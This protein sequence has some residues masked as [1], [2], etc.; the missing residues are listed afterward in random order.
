MSIGSAIVTNVTEYAGAPAAT[1]LAAD[2]FAVLCHDRSFADAA[3]RAAWE[4][5]NPGLGAAVAAT[6]EDLV[7][8]AVARFGGLDVL[9]SNDSWPARRARIEDA[10]P[11]EYRAMLEALTVQ[12]FRL[13]GAAA[14][15]M[16]Q[17]GMKEQG[18][19]RMVF[20][21][22]ASPLHACPGFSMYASA[23]AG[24]TA[25]A[26]ALARELAP[27]GIQVNAVLPNFLYSETYYPKALWQDDPRYVQRLKDLVPMQRL[28]QPGEIGALIAFLASGKAGFVT[29]QAIAFTGGWP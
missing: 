22:S 5:E 8:E 29:G 12:P 10:D 17:Q 7:A 23:R 11:V 20:I 4:G 25:L 18:R 13:A 19:G 15:V 16:K 6:P 27:S 3:A 9:V 14:R 28:G 24:A 1:A 26:E 21:T 2:G